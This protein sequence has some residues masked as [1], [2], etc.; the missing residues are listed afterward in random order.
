MDENLENEI[1]KAA[2]YEAA[3]N[4]AVKYGPPI[5]RRTAELGLHYIAMARAASASD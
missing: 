4:L 2:A 3:R 1:R 5:D